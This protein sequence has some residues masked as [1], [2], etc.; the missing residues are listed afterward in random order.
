MIKSAL[1]WIVQFLMGLTLFG[2]FGGT[3]GCK[4]TDQAQWERQLQTADKVQEIME[5]NGISGYVTVESNGSPEVYIKTAA[6]ID[7][8]IT[9]RAHV[10]GNAQ[11]SNAEQAP[12]VAGPLPATKPDGPPTPIGNDD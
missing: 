3:T 2:L 5:K 8:N 7:T 4:T 6:G 12:T 10:Q 9:L 1:V 11:N